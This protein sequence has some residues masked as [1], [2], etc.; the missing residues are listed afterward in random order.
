VLSLY[1]IGL[2]R[3][4]TLVRCN[5]V[6]AWR[7]KI[8]DSPF[9]RVRLGRAEGILF[10]SLHD[11]I[12][13]RGFFLVGGGFQVRSR[14]GPVGVSSVKLRCYGRFGPVGD[15][16]LWQIGIWSTS[17]WWRGRDTVYNSRGNAPVPFEL[18]CVLLRQ[19]LQGVHFRRHFLQGASGM[20]QSNVGFGYG[21]DGSGRQ[22]IRT[23]WVAGVVDCCKGIVAGLGAEGITH[24]TADCGVRSSVGAGLSRCSGLLSWFW[25]DGGQGAGGLVLRRA[26]K[27][28]H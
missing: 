11:G 2:Q 12:F 19:G 15:C 10:S 9:P 27:V 1:V 3:R 18:G 4:P 17:G 26:E 25:G 16:C 7:I 28:G 13:G 6:C 5:R 20:A 14:R 23:L 8:S 22:V 21:V 24:G